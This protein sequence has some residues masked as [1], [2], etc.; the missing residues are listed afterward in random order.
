MKIHNN[1]S[2]LPAQLSR[3]PLLVT[4][5]N[6]WRQRNVEIRQHPHNEDM[7]VSDGVTFDGSM[8]VICEE[9]KSAWSRELNSG[10]SF[11]ITD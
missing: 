1:T 5:K 8:R 2:F 3:L 11:L 9:T 7:V 4:V 10:K 6:N